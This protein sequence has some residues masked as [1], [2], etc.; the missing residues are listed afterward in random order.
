MKQKKTDKDSQQKLNKQTPPKNS[1]LLCYPPFVNG[2]E[3]AHRIE[4][5]INNRF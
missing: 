3:I 5:S 2:F 1:N 4:E